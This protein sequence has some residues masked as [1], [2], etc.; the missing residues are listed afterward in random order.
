MLNID[1]VNF[2]EKRSMLIRDGHPINIRDWIFKIH[3]SSYFT[4]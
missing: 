1:Y 3:Y 2:D 4:H